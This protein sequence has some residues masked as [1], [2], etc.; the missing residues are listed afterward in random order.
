MCRYLDPGRLSDL[1]E[2]LLLKLIAELRL[3]A[4]LPDHPGLFGAFLYD[5]PLKLVMS[6]VI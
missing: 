5:L 6:L 3:E 2:K 4:K 1:A